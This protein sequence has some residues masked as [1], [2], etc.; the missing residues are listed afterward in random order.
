MSLFKVNVLSDHAMQSMISF[1]VMTLLTFSTLTLLCSRLNE[2]C[3]C[4]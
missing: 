2:T 3:T 4:Q 1:T